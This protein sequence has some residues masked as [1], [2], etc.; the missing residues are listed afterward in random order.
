MVCT[1][2]T[3]GEDLGGVGAGGRGTD[4]GTVCVAASRS[5]ALIV[6][7]GYKTAVVHGQCCMVVEGSQSWTLKGLCYCPIW[8][9]QLNGI[10]Y[11][12][13]VVMYVSYVV[14]YI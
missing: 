2:G 14:M 11:R 6:H 8:V 7:R 12:M 5:I 13:Y 4:G 3:A 9:V 10:C 1:G